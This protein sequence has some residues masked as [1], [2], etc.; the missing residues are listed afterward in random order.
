MASFP[1]HPDND[2]QR[3]FPAA[4]MSTEEI[5]DVYNSTDYMTPVAPPAI[6]KHIY[7]EAIDI[8]RPYGSHQF[9][10]S[11]ISSVSIHP[12]VFQQRKRGETSSSRGAS[13]TTHDH[14]FAGG[15]VA[16]SSGPIRIR[17][18]LRNSSHSPSPRDVRFRRRDPHEVT[19]QSYNAAKTNVSTE[20]GPDRH[21]SHRGYQQLQDK[22]QPP[23]SVAP[24]VSTS[25]RQSSLADVIPASP[26]FPYQSDPHLAHSTSALS[27]W[28]GQGSV[29]LHSE[30][31]DATNSNPSHH[32]NNATSHILPGSDL[33]SGTSAR[34]EHMTPFQLATTSNAYP[35]THQDAP[36][37]PLL[38]AEPFMQ[39]PSF[40]STSSHFDTTHP[41]PS[42]LTYHGSFADQASQPTS[43]PFPTE[44][45]NE[46]GPPPIVETPASSTL[47]E[48]N[49]HHERTEPFLS[50][51]SP[52]VDNP[53]TTPNPSSL[54]FVHTSESDW[55]RLSVDVSSPST[56]QEP[57]EPPDSGRNI[58]NA[59][60]E[61]KSDRDRLFTYLKKEGDVYLC[62][63]EQNG[64]Q[65]NK[66][67]LRE[68]RALDHVRLHTGDKPYIC[69]GW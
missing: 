21:Y 31:N 19:A 38:S 39:N 67:I 60:N 66:L 7:K 28:D 46:S 9:G 3:T 20:Q 27:E 4:P 47:T 49:L 2:S 29:S 34:G 15:K 12:P 5:A 59:A 18:G 11:A 40:P 52:S 42:I 57:Q 45:S 61:A 33:L 62:L 54:S 37:F 26:H 22:A 68:C 14:G 41:I 30:S 13:T 58:R 17:H 43:G 32:M 44:A 51:R 53:A 35:L 36:S 48:A 50:I 25:G 55:P 65:C 56:S 24:S 69:K 6:I 63:Y 1:P 23:A 16:P 8:Q 64:A 10:H